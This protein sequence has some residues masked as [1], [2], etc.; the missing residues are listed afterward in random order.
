MDD[1]T[2]SNHTKETAQ[3]STDLSAEEA[4]KAAVLIQKTY[5]GHRT[6]RE[7]NGF[8]LDASTRWYEAVRDARF[9]QVTT[10]RPPSPG[11]RSGSPDSEANRTATPSSPARSKWNRAT[12]I[13]RRAGADDRSPS[14][15]D[16]SSSDMSEEEQGF[17]TMPTQE[18][19]EAARKRRG[20]ANAVRKKTAKVMDLQYFLE[21]VDQKHRYGSNLRKYHNY[22]KT[23]DTD[24]SYFYWLDQGDGRTVELPECSRARLDKEQVR[25]LSREERLQYLVKVNSEGLLV[26]AKNGELVW[27]KDELFKDSVNGIVPIDDPSPQWKYNVPP[28]GKSDSSSSSSD[29]PDDTEEGEGERYVNEEFHRA[30]GPSKVKHVSAGVLFNHMI[31]T[32]LKKGHKWIFVADTSFRLYIGYKQSGAF[33]HS[34]F[35]HGARILSAGLIKVKHGQLRK[36]SPLSGHY[37]PPA[38]NFRAFVHSLRDAGADMSHVSI[39]RSYAVLVGLETYTKA[40][41]Q[42]KS[43]EDSVVHEKDELLNPDKVRMEEEAQRDKSQSAETER[44]YLKKQREAED[45]EF[46]ERKAKRSLTG[47]LSNAI[48]KLRFRGVS[49]DNAP[50]GEEQ[51]K[52]IMGTGPEDGVP[53]PEGHR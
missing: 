28:A 47:R 31:R 33:Q 21:M 45:R 48:S 16:L 3:P 13:A 52:R 44:L 18:E 15:S 51:A 25:Y 8:G 39:S 43:A 35:L 12:E 40:R 7:L 34:S 53:P 17:G 19:K 49:G 4:K 32:S 27:T 24:Q 26:W 20:E 38:A 41:K 6:R 30:R 46:R 14:V 2:T 10:P 42:L 37:R 36:L 9:K 1:V 50:V 22:W 5:R 29:E 11:G 23:Q